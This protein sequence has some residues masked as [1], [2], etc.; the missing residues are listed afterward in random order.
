MP[1]ELVK[2]VEGGGSSEQAEQESAKPTEAPT[3]GEA[4]A[5]APEGQ[6]QSSAMEI[7]DEGDAAA[8]KD[9][10]E[11]G[12]SKEGGAPPQDK[13]DAAKEK[14]QPKDDAGK[15]NGGPNGAAPSAD[16]PRELGTKDSWKPPLP[17]IPII[18]DMDPTTKLADH[19]LIITL[20]VLPQLVRYT[21][22][23]R[24]GLVSR[25]WGVGHDGNSIRVI[26][27]EKV[28]PREAM[29]RA[30][31]SMRK[32]PPTFGANHDDSDGYLMVMESKLTAK[33]G[34]EVE[35]L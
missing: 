5:K 6:E 1:E 23:L 31:H 2:L 14:E 11:E 22:S 35:T 18:G 26:A 28:P 34:G 33:R 12:R 7:S 32:G 4:G 17:R 20:R 13:D 9:G 27:C 8:K 3:G 10:A 19:D 29:Q 30:K 25:G 15:E 24:C 21:G 16:A